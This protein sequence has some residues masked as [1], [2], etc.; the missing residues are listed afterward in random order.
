MK[1]SPEE[2]DRFCANPPRNLT[3]ALLYGD[4]GLVA[5]RRDRLLD[6]VAGGPDAERERL[7]GDAVRRDPGA[8]DSALC[9]QSFFASTR[10][11]LLTE[12]GDGVT[13]AIRS[14]L[15]GDRAAAVLV[16]TAG[17]LKAA[18]SLRKLFE[19]EPRAAAVPC[20]DA[21]LSRAAILERLDAAGAPSPDAE[22]QAA[23]E[24]LC[25]SMDRGAALSEIDKL[26]LYKGPDRTPITAEDVRAAGPAAQG[27]DVEAALHA[28]SAGDPALVRR[29]LS[30]IVAA[31]ADP[32]TVAAAAL[33]RARTLQAAAAISAA[34]R[35]DGRTALER[36]RPPVR[37]PV[38]R[39]LAPQVPR[40]SG[41]PGEEAVAALL[42]LSTRL[43]EGAGRSGPGWA[44]T[45]R[46]LIRIAMTLGRR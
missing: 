29:A 17:S 12:A 11:V 45:E 42:D 19:A 1:V 7:S 27:D 14:A 20:H 16:A 24:A 37:F 43:R 28:V 23:L 4:P 3:A 13:A 2:A 38:N 39:A 15:G 44:L 31:G 36:L 41:R 22:G 5:E 21:P 32:G 10:A 18:S 46:T 33:R 8:L 25:V 40:W 34:E 26:A 6:A 35:C 9:S 30:T